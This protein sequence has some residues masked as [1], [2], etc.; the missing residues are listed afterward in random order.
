MRADRV[1]ITGAEVVTCL[2]A[3]REETW[4]VVRWRGG[5]GG[6]CGMGPLTAL[7]SPLPPGKVGGQAVELPAEYEPDAPR[8]VRY[9]KW[10]IERALAEAGAWPTLTYE[11]QR[12]GVMLGTTLQQLYAR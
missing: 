12:C 9:L 5:G 8:E 10:T 7:E 4:R 11:A 6:L 1:V 2:G 3:S